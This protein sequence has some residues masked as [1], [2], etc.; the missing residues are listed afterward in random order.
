[1]KKLSIALLFAAAA[2][3]AMA[4]DN[5]GLDKNDKQFFEKAAAGGMFEVEAGKLAE[6]K[7]QTAEV[8][9]FGSMLVK[10]HSAANEELKALAGKKGV[11]LPTALP[12]DMQKKI[13][14][15]SK[16]DKKFDHEFVEDVGLHDHKKDIS[17]FEKTAK[18]SKDADIKA[19]A[20]KTLP[21]LQAH[22]QQAETLKKAAKGAKKA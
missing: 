3:A 19:F 17:L 20:S 21:T 2:G 22:H 14:K 10:D 8:K 5:A 9:S 6:S 1:M 11:T 7:G 18:N 13:A 4:A 15:L 12:K 16:E